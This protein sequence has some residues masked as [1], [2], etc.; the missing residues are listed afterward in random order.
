M[1]PDRFTR[2]LAPLRAGEAVALAD[3]QGKALAAALA[4]PASS[5]CARVYHRDPRAEF[6]PRAGGA[7]GLAASDALHADADTDCYRLVHGEADGLPAIRVERYGTA[8]V[9][10]ATAACALP[11]VDAVAAEIAELMPS[12][13]LLL[14]TQLADLRR[15][16][17]VDRALGGW[18]IDPE[19]VVAGRELGVS[20]PLRPWSG[21]ATGLYVDQRG[22]RAWLRGRCQ[23]ARVLN[24]FAY[25]GAFSLSLLAGGAAA[26]GDVDLSG[27]A[28][29]PARAA[30]EAAG[31]GAR[32]RAVQDDCRAA[33]AGMRESFDIV[34]VDPPTAAQGGG[35]WVLRRDYPALLKLAWERV[36]S[37]GVLVAAAN[38]QGGDP[39][40]IERWMDQACPRSSRLAPPAL[41][42]DLPQLQGFPEGRPFRLGARQRA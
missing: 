21:L 18:T 15:G 1:R 39:V 20:Y 13:R 29:A 31:V 37:R 16:T 35:G 40:P 6:D 10:L 27:P 24:L 2:G 22:T 23:G 28:L 32:H 5:V 17:T 7:R 36:G 30:A 19:E 33:L 3:Q 34:I 41:G 11:H 38:T 12:A 25:T 14:R 9:L 8:V 42:P 26:A 4:D